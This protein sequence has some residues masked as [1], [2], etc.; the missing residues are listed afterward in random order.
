MSQHAQADVL[1]MECEW[2]TD[3]AQEARVL[4]LLSSFITYS[5]L[6]N[7]MRS[8]VLLRLVGGKELWKSMGAVSSWCFGNM[9]FPKQCGHT[10]G[11]LTESVKARCLIEVVS[12]VSGQFP[13]NFR[14]KW[15]L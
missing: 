8:H 12:G 15:L 9:F 3:T 13:L 5:P 14:T 4:V 1:I 10:E 2:D 7:S 6:G 11:V